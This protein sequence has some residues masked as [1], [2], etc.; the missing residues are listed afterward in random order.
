MLLASLLLFA[1]QAMAGPI[2]I[3]VSEPGV[4][5]LELKCGSDVRQVS[6]RNGVATLPDIP[7]NCSVFF[8]QPSGAIGSPGKYTC[9][10]EGCVLSEIDHRPVSDGDGIINIILPPESAKGTNSFELTCPSGYRNRAMIDR[11]VATFN[12]VPKESCSLFF[13]GGSPMRANLSDWGSYTCQVVGVTP[14][15]RK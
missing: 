6:V 1:S 3:T 11:N 8:I 7:G 13:K 10:L 4:E 12:D 2:E 9:S 14:I 5:R 15:C